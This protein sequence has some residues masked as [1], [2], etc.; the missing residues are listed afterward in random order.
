MNIVVDKNITYSKLK[1][2]FIFFKKAQ[3]LAKRTMKDYN[4]TF[5]R[6]EKYYTEDVINVEAIKFAL[7]E[8]FDKL[9]NGAPATF[10]VPFSNLMCFFNW[11][12]D[13]EYMQKNP[14]KIIGLKKKKDSFKF[15]DIC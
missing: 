2:Q 11:C 7:L 15:L 10:N 9:S 5:S 12:V 14:L 8:M 4:N 13:N 1:K 3:G 6:F